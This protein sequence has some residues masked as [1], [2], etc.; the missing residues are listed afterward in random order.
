MGVRARVL[1]LFPGFHLVINP[2][3]WWIGVQLLPGWVE[4]QPLPC[5]G[6]AF[7]RRAVARCLR[8][9]PVYDRA[10]RYCG[11]CGGSIEP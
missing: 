10:D 3:S 1:V 7:R 2:D 4:V 5:V 6:F 9:H 11:E 8:G